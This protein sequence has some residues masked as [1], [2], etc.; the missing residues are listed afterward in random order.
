MK[1]NLETNNLFGIK[2]RAS[3]KSTSNAKID[4]AVNQHASFETEKA[5]SEAER[6]KAEAIIILR[7]HTSLR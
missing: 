5:T 1:T 6:K 7:G 4:V 3:Q 2:K